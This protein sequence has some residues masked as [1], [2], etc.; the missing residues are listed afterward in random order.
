MTKCVILVL[1]LEVAL[2]LVGIWVINHYDL[3]IDNFKLVD[4]GLWWK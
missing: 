1:V 3:Q 4:L 2:C